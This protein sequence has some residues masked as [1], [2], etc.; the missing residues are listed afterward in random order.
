VSP[1]VAV[2]VYALL[3][4]AQYG[5]AVAS[6]EALG[7]VG[8]DDASAIGADDGGRAQYESRRGAIGE[9]SRAVL[10]A[11]FAKL[12]VNGAAA[13][14]AQLDAEAIGPNGRT[15]PQFTSGIEIGHAMGAVM[16]TWASNDGFTASWDQ[17][18]WLSGTP[19]R[20]YQASATVGPAGFQFPTMRPYFLERNAQF[21]P[22]H[23]PEYGSSEFLD[24]LHELQGIIAARTPAQVNS[25][26]FWN[27]P[28]G[29][30]TALGYWDDQAAGYIVEHRLGDRSASHILALTN[31][32]AFDATIGCWETKY[33][34]GLLRPFQADPTITAR[35]VFLTPNHP[36]FPSGHSC[37]SAA[38]ATVLSDFFPE[39][40]AE[41]EAGVAAAGMSRLYA[42][43]HYPF[44][45]VAGQT[46]G[47]S[48]AKWALNYDRTRGL[49][50]AVGR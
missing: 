7:I 21:H 26:N 23:V 43:I 1:L 50:R 25:A 36:S 11:L 12:E 13:M 38:A 15:H 34:V 32:A 18:A 35:T 47:R 31:A 6:D 8:G 14:Q 40:T 41:L 48:T 5:A 33:S 42:G 16:N 49:L 17:H 9:A 46:L 37:V 4:V 3:G 10:T 27:L 24:G 20:W 39:K 28:G 22:Q 45:I 44:D 29:T 2:R 19:G 30:P